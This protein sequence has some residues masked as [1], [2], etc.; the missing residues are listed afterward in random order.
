MLRLG[1][2]N[3]EDPQQ[4]FKRKNKFLSVETEKN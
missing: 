1:F 4:S 3:M 2:F